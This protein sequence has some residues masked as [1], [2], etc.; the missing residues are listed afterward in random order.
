MWGQGVLNTLAT[1][2][3]FR[4]R[5]IREIK[6]V[7]DILADPCCE[8]FTPL[9]VDYDLI[10]VNNSCSWSFKRQEFVNGAIQDHQIGKVSPRAFCPFDAMR[11]PDPKYFR[12]VLENSLEPQ[13]VPKFC[14]DFLKPLSYNKK[15]HKDKVPCLVG[16]AN[17][18]KPACSFPF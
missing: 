6:K 4:S 14:D 12:E 1:N 17:S 2:K 10:E 13:E 8:L 16:D 3:F 18:A 9:T 7:N 15:R 11:D 5:L